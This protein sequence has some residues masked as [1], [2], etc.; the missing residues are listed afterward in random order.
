[1]DTEQDSRKL[2]SLKPFKD[3]RVSGKISEK[4]GDPIMTN[5]HAVHDLRLHCERNTRNK[6]VLFPWGLIYPIIKTK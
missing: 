5:N 4:F 2:K 3:K 1:M 6:K